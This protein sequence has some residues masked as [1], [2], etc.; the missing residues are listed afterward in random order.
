MKKLSWVLTGVMSLAGCGGD[1]G[2]ERCEDPKYGDGTCDLQT[3]CTV[4]DIDCFTTFATQS[5]AQAWFAS[6]QVAATRPPLPATDARFARMQALL[7]E[8]W[9]AYKSV[10]DVGDLKSAQVHLVLNA[11]PTPNAFVISKDGKAGLVVMV[12]T[13]L[14]DLGAPDEELMGVVM[15]EL[16]HTIGLHV[17]PEV[18]AGFTRYYLAPAGMEPFGFEQLDHPMVRSLVEAWIDHAE[19]VGYLSDVELRGLPM[20][21]ELATIF[22]KRLAMQ[23]ATVGCT[24]AKT[25]L[26]ALRKTIA[27]ALDPIDDSITLAS[28][29]PMTIQTAMGNLQTQCFAGFTMDAIDVV[30]A[31]LGV[32]RAQMLTRIPADVRPMLEGQPYI[33]GMYNWGIYLRAKMREVEAKFMTMTGQPWSRARYFSTEEAADDSSVP[34]LRAMGLAAD[35]AGKIFPKLKP[36][37]EEKCR[38]LVTARASIPYGEN[39]ED[40]HHGLCWRAGHIDALAASGRVPQRAPFVLTPRERTIFSKPLLEYSH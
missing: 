20:L 35:G 40:T 4:P 6:S 29:A 26:N 2:E 39:V 19:T 22:D 8:G 7:D 28:T 5:E 32:T 12:T 1:E 9:D 25:D 18:K 17:I 16:E 31:A 34:T 14:I 24:T 36:G 33:Q 13:E 30:A 10:N 37:V 21:G 23:P 3:S 15:H 11:Q 38:P 27:G